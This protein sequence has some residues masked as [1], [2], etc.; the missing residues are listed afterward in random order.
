[1]SRLVKLT[2]PFAF[3]SIF[4]SIVEVT[5]AIIIGKL[6]S[7]DELT[8]F[9][10]VDMFLGTTS[11][12][13]G[14]VIDTQIMLLNHAIGAGNNH[15]AKQHA[16]TST[17]SYVL[18]QMPAILFWRHAIYSLI[19]WLGFNNSIATHAQK[20]ANVAVFCDL[21]AGVIEGMHC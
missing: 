5:F 17:M 13:V 1:M 19:I 16:Q 12:F 3:N 6:M 21:V 18:L 20:Y 14:G 9:V 4:E 11:E 15:V 10:V 7:A 2:I 8:T